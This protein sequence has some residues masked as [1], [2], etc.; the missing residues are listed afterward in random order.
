MHRPPRTSQSHPL[1]IAEVLVGPGLGK[2][3]VTFC[4][5][6]TDPHGISASWVRDLA[7][8]LKA[9]EAW[10]AAAVVTLM[11]DHELKLLQVPSLGQE[12]V[13]LH[14]A[15]V[16]LPI[17]DV[18][19]PDA[20]FER[21][22]AKEGPRLR[23]LLRCGFNVLVHCRG[24]LGRSGM[25]AARL[26]VELGW[27]PSAAIR[28]VRLVRPGAIETAQ[29]EAYAAG[30]QTVS[31]APPDR[32]DAA[33]RDRAMGA[34]LGLAVGDALGT[35]LEF[36]HRDQ[37]PRLTDMV[38]G[39]PFRL[40]PGQWTDDTAM[41]V[42]LATSLLNTGQQSPPVDFDPID[43]MQ[44]FVAWRQQGEYSCTGTCFDIGITTQSALSRF[45]RDG[46]P[47]AGLYDLNAAGNGSLM[48]LAPAAV[49]CWRDSEAAVALAGR[50]SITTHGAPEAVD[51]CRAYAQLLTEAI[52]GRAKVE[53]LAP[54]KGDW[55]PKI[56][57]ILGGSWRGK[58][59]AEISS[60]GYVVPSLE[61]ALWCVGRSGSFAEAVLMAANLGDDADT[62]AAIT[63]QLAGALW[64]ASSI[65]S[66]WLEKL[67]WRQEIERLAGELF[68]R[69]GETSA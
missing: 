33:T 1:Q 46:N 58:R 30:I 59:Q 29:Q 17:V 38:G 57:H 47:N 65:P 68:E 4:P 7:L 24:G 2:V 61:A 52:Q 5:G 19:T 69:R 8:D 23:D 9:I 44:R 54:R 49:A 20:A 40:K 64:G 11:E 15:W 63:G 42:A 51:A 25:I 18:S 67:A 53:V 31:P 56:A 10:G 66:S 26:L 21:A 14:M 6:K 12:V 62:V 3:G 45:V 28:A 41:A 37:Y 60:S 55:A 16:H 13:K 50:Q 36:S 32:S 48:R 27:Q 39:G 43:L 22:W 34:F 35:T